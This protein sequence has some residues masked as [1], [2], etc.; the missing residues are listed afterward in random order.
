MS[1]NDSS[2]KRAGSK[3]AGTDHRPDRRGAGERG[4]TP[5]SRAPRDI[6]DFLRFLEQVEEI[7]GKIRKARTIT[8][9]SRFVL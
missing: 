9:G 3:P 1:S 4:D 8:V 2:P 7:G 5:A 6:D